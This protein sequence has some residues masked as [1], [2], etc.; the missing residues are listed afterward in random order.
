M[1]HQ[2]DNQ[3]KEVKDP[4]MGVPSKVAGQL[5]A[6]TK[7][8]KIRSCISM[9]PAEIFV[10]WDKELCELCDEFYSPEHKCKKMGSNYLIVG[11]DEEEDQRQSDLEVENPP[12]MDAP[13]VL[14]ESPKSNPDINSHGWVGEGQGKSSV[15][16]HNAFGEQLDG[17]N[18]SNGLLEQ[19]N[20]C[21]QEELGEDANS[22]MCMEEALPM[23]AGYSK[24]LGLK[25]IVPELKDPNLPTHRIPKNLGCKEANGF[26]ELVFYPGILGPGQSTLQ[27]N[28]VVF[29]SILNAWVPSHQWKA[30]SGVLE[31][32]KKGGLKTNSA[33]YGLAKE[34]MLHS[35]KY[36]L[37]H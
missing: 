4:L 31:K 32:L 23:L 14:D 11:V 29:N 5:E 18:P 9:S 2:S 20:L 10:K 24:A 19:S 35:K 37:V 6:V 34:V 17:L 22:E 28:I 16:S 33:T 21:V 7:G 26:Y 36:D 13:Q 1:E 15:G 8:K 3:K 25:S 30:I 12:S 27:P